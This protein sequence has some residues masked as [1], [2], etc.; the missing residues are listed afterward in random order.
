[1]KKILRRF[2]INCVSFFGASILIEGI[3]FDDGLY[4]LG[5]IGFFL[6]LM[7]MFLKPV[8]KVLT[9]PFNLL[10]FGLFSWFLNVIILYL[11]TRIVEKIKIT[12]F[13]FQGFEY[14]GFVI[15]GMHLGIWE[16]MVLG[17]MVIYLI[18]SFLE[19]IAD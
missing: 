9:L 10:T 5:V 2:L 13:D 1:M 11:L 12:A 18:S 7:N 17:A 19:W 8:L 15:P 14:G 16:T 6:T 4:S 3:S